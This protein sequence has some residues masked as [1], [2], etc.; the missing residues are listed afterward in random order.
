MR[1]ALFD[2]LRH[3]TLRRLLRVIEHALAAVG[4]VFIAYHVAFDLSVM[5]SGSMSPTLKGEGREGSDHILTEKVSYWFRGP[6]RWEIVTFLSEEGERRTKR[7]VGLPG[8][9][10]SLT[11]DGLVVSG[12]SVAFPE[13]LAFLQYYPYGNL[14]RGASVPCGDGYY[15][16]GDDS[17]DSDDSRY[18]GPVARDAIIGRTWLRAWPP[19]RFGSVNP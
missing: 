11:S 16:L 9:T 7:V 19:A 14:R 13:A 6:R 3:K 2:F 15:V 17:R 5:T 1:R 18:N 4:A 8:E 12:A 10:V